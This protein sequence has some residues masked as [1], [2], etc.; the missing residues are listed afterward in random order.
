MSRLFFSLLMLMALS[1]PARAERVTIFAA[2]SLKG[3]LDQTLLEAGIDAVAVYGGSAAMAR[4]VAQ[5]AQADIVLLAHPD[6][7]DWLEAKGLLDSTSRCDLLGNRLVLAGPADRAD[8]WPTSA[9]ELI[10]ALEGGR[11]ATGHL[12]AVPAGQYT[13]AFLKD[14]GWLD[15][16]HPHLAETGNVRLAL[17]LVA[18]GEAPLGFVYASDVQAEPRLRA[19]FVPQAQASPVIRYPLAMT[20]NAKPEAVAVFV[21]LIAGRDGFGRFGFTARPEGEGAC[22]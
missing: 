22:P 12:E 1:L 11:L 18:R 6:W 19:V 14:M 4:Q 5:G 16:L 21:R 20:K 9:A 8:I 13:A 3:A 15:A 17:Q 7:M 10:A 2:A